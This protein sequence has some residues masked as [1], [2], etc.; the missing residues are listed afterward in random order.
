MSTL[1]TQGL[2]VQVWDAFVYSSNNK[3]ENMEEVPSS[4]PKKKKHR[5]EKDYTVSRSFHDT[6]QL[7]CQEATSHGI[8]HA[9]NNRFNLLGVFWL[10]V[11]AI[12]LGF[13][14]YYVIA[15]V[16][17]FMQRSGK[18]QTTSLMADNGLQIPSV[19]LCN[20]GLY[21]KRKM[22]A[23]NISDSMVSYLLLRLGDPTLI[24][25]EFLATEEGEEYLSET[26]VYFDELLD[27]LNFT[28][29][30]LVDAISYDQ[31]T[32]RCYL[33]RPNSKLRRNFDENL[34]F[35]ARELVDAISY[36]CEEI[37]LMCTVSRQTLTGKECCAAMIDI[38]TFSG[39]CYVYYSNHTRE[40]VQS[41]EGE[42]LG[43]S[44]YVRSEVD[45]LPV[46]DPKVIDLTQIMK[47]GHQMSLFSNQTHPSLTAV[48]H[49]V[50]LTPKMYTT[51]EVSL[52]EVKDVGLKTLVDWNVD[53]CVPTTSIGYT[54]DRDGFYR[55]QPNC[56]FGAI[57][58]CFV[59]FCN[60]SHYALDIEDD[61][62]RPC[63]LKELLRCYALAF[64]NLD[65]QPL[66]ED[67]LNY[68]KKFASKKEVLESRHCLNSVARGCKR[69]CTRFDYSYTSSQSPINPTIYESLHQQFSLPNNS[70]LAVSTCFFPNM[71]YAEIRLWRDSIGNL[72]SS[73]GGITGVL[74]GCSIV[75]FIEFFVAIALFSAI[76]VRFCRGKHCDK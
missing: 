4:I 51:T 22:Q 11:T 67:S 16:M 54:A 9:W 75:S 42:F 49:G 41:V 37:L 20:R 66:T 33:L 56:M 60:C 53:E 46:L 18:S 73:I 15:L 28:A 55:I 13:L 5:C 34:N 58:T 50:S 57:R 35:T 76:L 69:P 19:A 10:I 72:I 52:V 45:D 63:R 7:L 68:V 27:R 8:G 71:R 29:R 31:G 36:D 44:L 21:S 2:V 47:T 32:R 38:P 70:E 23:L 43:V 39:K 1:K 48:G 6:V 61:N 12:L 25:E 14:W 3:K 65:L 30:E 26:N 17:E 40:N 74:L 62:M 64:Q 24:R 59:R